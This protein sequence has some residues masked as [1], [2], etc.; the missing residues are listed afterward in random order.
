[1]HDN[2]GGILPCLFRRD[3]YGPVARARADRHHPSGAAP[4]RPVAQPFLASPKAMSDS[5]VAR[6]PELRSESRRPVT[7]KPRG[8]FSVRIGERF[9]DVL[10]VHNVSTTGLR[11]HVAAPIGVSTPIV[12]HYRDAAVDVQLNGITCWESPP[13]DKPD[14]PCTIGIE[15]LSPTTLLNLV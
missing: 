6:T 5:I 12:L 15:L 10:D 3:G 14:G 13:D 11:L 2:T 4:P 8:G 1:L 9:V 7:R